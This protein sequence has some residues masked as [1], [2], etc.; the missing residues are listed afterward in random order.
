MNERVK[1]LTKEDES[2]TT[3]QLFDHIQE[4]AGRMY[5]TN[6]KLLW[7][8]CVKNALCCKK[9]DVKTRYIWSS[10]CYNNGVPF[11]LMFNYVYRTHRLNDQNAVLD[12][13]NSWNTNSMQRMSKMTNLLT[14]DRFCLSRK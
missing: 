13:I 7:P 4:L 1:Y 5:D 14:Y 10:F 2:L 6:N 12:I 11:G 9:F 3:I 8:L